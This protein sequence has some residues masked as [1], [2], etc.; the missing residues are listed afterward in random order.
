MDIPFAAA[1]QTEEN[2]I[3]K[4]KAIIDEDIEAICKKSS[5]ESEEVLSVI[6]SSSVENVRNGNFE[7][8]TAEKKKF[9]KSYN[10]L[11]KDVAYA[12]GLN[13]S[14]I[15]EILLNLKELN[16]RA[17]AEALRAKSKAN[18]WLISHY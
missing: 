18:R 4:L 14:E 16:S 2:D 6:S 17:L 9:V 7:L 12:A 15:N 13:S 10:V 11:I 8:S 5:I 1:Q 3:L